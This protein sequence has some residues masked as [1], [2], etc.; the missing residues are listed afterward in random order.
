MFLRRTLVVA[1]LA[2]AVGTT[3]HS[4]AMREQAGALGARI[5]AEDGVGQAVNALHRFLGG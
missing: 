5:R 3:V 4:R 2:G 1:G